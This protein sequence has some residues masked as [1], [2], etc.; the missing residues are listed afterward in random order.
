[1]DLEEEDTTNCGT[2]GAQCLLAMIFEEVRGLHGS[3]AACSGGSNGLFVECI[4]HISRSEYSWDV[5]E[6]AAGSCEDVSMGIH[7]HLS[8]EELCIWRMANGDKH[9][10][11]WQKGGCAIE[12]VC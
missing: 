7:L 5:R 3:L 11:C 10:V 9:T 2:P 12:Q 8:C 6:R 1:M 4:L